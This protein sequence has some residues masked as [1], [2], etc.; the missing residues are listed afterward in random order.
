VSSK[1]K[2]GDP[3]FVPRYPPLDEVL[4]TVEKRL[5][6]RDTTAN[7]LETRAPNQAEA[8]RSDTEMMRG[9]VTTVKSQRVA[10]E[11]L[12]G[13]IAEWR[14]LAQERKATE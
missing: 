13:E 11:I 2:P 4:A 10:N 12:K 9:L 3:D 1:P 7:L 6:E 5:E 8:I 14:R